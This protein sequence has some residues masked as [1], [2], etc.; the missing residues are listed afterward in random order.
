MIMINQDKNK[1][2]TPKFRL[3]AR[4]T[5]WDV[6]AQVVDAKIAGDEVIASA[7]AR[8]LSNY[9]VKAGFTNYAA[10]YCTGLLLA[11][12]CLKKLGLDDAFKGKETADGEEYHVEE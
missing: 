10:C 8:E 2:N 7:Y 4:V 6:I 12:R 5:N 3:V 1:Y 11:R 9:G